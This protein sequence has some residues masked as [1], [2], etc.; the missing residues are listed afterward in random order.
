MKTFVVK[1]TTINNGKEGYKSLN[2]TTVINNI[3]DAG[4]PHGLVEAYLRQL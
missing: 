3:N 1:I 2:R 4:I